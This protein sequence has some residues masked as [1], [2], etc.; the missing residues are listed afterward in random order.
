MEN[1]ARSKLQDAAW[2]KARLATV[3]Y[4]KPFEPKNYER[5]LPDTRAVVLNTVRTADEREEFDEMISSKHAEVEKL[6]RLVCIH[7]LK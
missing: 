5:P 4:K 1:E 3:I 7:N 6:K 2:F